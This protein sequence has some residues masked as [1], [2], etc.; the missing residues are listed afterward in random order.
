MRSWYGFRIA[1]AGVI[2]GCVMY[3]CLKNTVFVICFIPVHL[4]NTTY[5]GNNN[6]WV[7]FVKATC[8]PN[9]HQNI[10]FLPRFNV[11][12]YSTPH[13]GANVFN[14]IWMTHDDSCKPIYPAPCS[15]VGGD[16]RWVLSVA[17]DE[18]GLCLTQNQ[19]QMAL[20]CL[21]R[22]LSCIHCKWK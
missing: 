13:M 2:I 4:T 7:T 21:Y 20:E 18:L 3:L 5:N 19:N 22:V 6:V 9:S 15:I 1:S 11:E 12:L 8:L 14:Y 16:L 17:I 10:F